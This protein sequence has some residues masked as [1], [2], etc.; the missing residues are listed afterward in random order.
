MKFTAKLFRKKIG[1]DLDQTAKKLTETLTQGDI[2]CLIVG[3]YAL[4]EHGYHRNTVDI[5]VVVPSLELA[6]HYLSIRG[7]RPTGS[8]AILYDRATG[9]EVN[10]LPAGGQATTNS[11][12]PIPQVTQV[13]SMRVIP[14]NDLIEMKLNVFVGSPTKYLKH[15]VDVMELIKANNLSEAS[16]SS[17]NQIIQK[18]W[19][20]TWEET[21]SPD[22][23]P[24]WM[25]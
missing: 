22:E 13:G 20:Q 16:F 15:K 7:F 25:L 23:S 2:P 8:K 24:E 17:S 14:L 5:D 11:P 18:C 21:T 3:G 19:Q 12:L 9:I 1:S 4:Q 10:L 6:N